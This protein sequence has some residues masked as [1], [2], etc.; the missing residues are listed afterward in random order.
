MEFTA[1]IINYYLSVTLIVRQYEWRGMCN[2]DHIN[3]VLLSSN[4]FEDYAQKYL[5]LY[6]FIMTSDIPITNF[7]YNINLA[8]LCDKIRERPHVES[9]E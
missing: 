9:L 2:Y 4:E 1:S 5:Y 6:V 7:V 8:A 3:H